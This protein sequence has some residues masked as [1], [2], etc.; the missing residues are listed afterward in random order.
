M[1]HKKIEL[2]QSKQNLPVIQVEHDGHMLPI[3]SKYNPVNEA[4][5][6]IEANAAQL[7]A[8]DH[9][10][11]YGVGLGYHVKE[12]QMKYP[13]KIISVYEPIVEVYE[14]FKKNADRIGVSIEGIANQYV[15][16]TERDLVMHLSNFSINFAQRVFLLQLPIY[17][18]IAKDEYSN[19]TELYR[20]FLK[21]KYS[22]TR[23]EAKFKDRWAIN[24]L[25]NIKST[26]ETPNILEQKNNIFKGKP[27]LLVSA[28][29]SLSDEIE[30]IRH[31]K[32]NGLAFI[33]A[34]G[35]ANRALIANNIQPDAVLSYDP[36]S[37]NHMV[38][39]ELREK[40]I[41]DI[42]LLY[43][44]TVGYE[45]VQTFPGPLAHFVVEKDKLTPILHNVQSVTI[46]DS[47]TIANV[48]L[49]LLYK[50][51][52]GKIIL[53]G[54]NF[55]YKGNQFYAKGI[56]RWTPKEERTG[57]EPEQ[58]DGELFEKDLVAVFNVESVHG[59]QV[60]TN[61]TF[62]LMRREMELYISTLPNINIVNTTIG[63]AKIANAPFQT[64]ESIIQH[65]LIEKVVPANWW[66]QLEHHGRKAN[67]DKLL[68][69]EK[70][71]QAFPKLINKMLE[72]LTDLE[73]Y[74]KSMDIK[75]IDTILKNFY[76]R[77]EIFKKNH[78]VNTLIMPVI[79]Y[80][81]SKFYSDLSICNKMPV[82]TEKLYASVQI[83]RKYLLLTIDAYQKLAPFFHVKV[84]RPLR[85]SNSY[86]Y[87][88]STSGIFHF[89]GNWEKQV[90]EIQTNFEV[91]NT[92]ENEEEKKEIELERYGFS[93]DTV[94]S[95]T[96]LIFKFKGTKLQ[97]L[98][99]N[100][101]KE[102]LE[103]KVTIDGKSNLVKIEDT[104][105]KELYGT[106]QQQI[107]F[108]KLNLKNIMHEV[109][110]EI[111]SENPDFSFMGIAINKDG[112][113]Y[114]IHEVERIE[115]LEIGKRIR[116]YYEAKYNTVG[117]FSGLG[118]EIALHLSIEGTPEPSGDFYFIMVDENNG[119]K[120][121]IAD[122]NVQ[123]YI[124]W[125][126]L[127][128]NGVIEGNINL[129]KNLPNIISLLDGGNSYIEE[130]NL[131]KR[132]KHKVLPVNNEWNNYIKS[133]FNWNTENNV[134]WTKNKPE[135]GITHPFNK[136]LNNQI[137]NNKISFDEYAVARGGEG[138]NFTFQIQT[139]IGK[140][141]GFR[142]LL[143]L[144]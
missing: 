58:V 81:E 122:R 103:L 109:T 55:A 64:L 62:D 15:E 95:E 44:T 129:L 134:S 30:N 127:E 85:V 90:L 29:P 36:Q 79:Q 22:N 69:L 100:H 9:V 89:E 51:N 99:A 33:F 101:A 98:G 46:N 141:W 4:Q 43:G 104:F 128:R 38:F 41:N 88:E 97:I 140:G 12:V 92:E 113:A 11:F 76:A 93:V 54:Q 53:V 57:E 31:I 126:E 131:N 47:A 8:S 111:V 117:E 61:P 32:K 115:D 82:L 108:E 96:Q 133:S 40:Q 65:E 144:K 135:K 56:T 66:E 16:H 91:Q 136:I 118:E 73:T 42:P 23:V 107:L 87:Y 14:E 130:N 1:A 34:V 2:L 86:K 125:L 13:E 20:R 77:F 71:S 132:S 67:Q 68:N 119:N 78:F 72:I 39:Q 3:H 60:Q 26:F 37:H 24:M 110:V 21:D 17:E 52:V 137:N 19:F 7:K 84:Y 80:Y 123:N 94:N 50:L 28:G 27:V 116:C 45:T 102:L 142:P 83:Y 63:G 124:S 112:R 121:L 114:H 49:Q 70:G 138:N 105:N 106:F 139:L 18:K 74:H 25:M 5:R 75:K 143:I 59:S 6:F 120:K 10:L 48:T 35:S